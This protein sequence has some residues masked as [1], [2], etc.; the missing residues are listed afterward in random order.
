ME[1]RMTEQQKQTFIKEQIVMYVRENYP[2]YKI[3]DQGDNVVFE[4]K[5]PAASESN[6]YNWQ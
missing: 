2:Q 3:D 1:I 4:G 6:V 5:E